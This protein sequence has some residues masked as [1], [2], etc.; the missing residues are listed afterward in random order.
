MLLVQ[1]ADT[2]LLCKECKKVAELVGNKISGIHGSS[3]IIA[4]IAIIAL[5]FRHPINNCVCAQ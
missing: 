5:I 3:E 2:A 4:V 1:H